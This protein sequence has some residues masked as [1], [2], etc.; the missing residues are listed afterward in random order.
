MVGHVF[1]S[2]RKIIII[3]KYSILVV[4][5]LIC[6]RCTYLKN[7]TD[8]ISGYPASV[9]KQVRLENEFEIL[10]NFIQFLTSRLDDVFIFASSDIWAS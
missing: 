8:T 10:E 5:Y 1:A 4:S 9:P 7:P 6:E 3:I 2:K